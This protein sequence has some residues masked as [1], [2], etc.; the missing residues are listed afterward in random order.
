MLAPLRRAVRALAYTAAFTAICT[1]RA[2]AQSSPPSDF[3]TWEDSI[4]SSSWSARAFALFRLSQF[5]KSISATGR[6][7]LVQLLG[8]ELDGTIAPPAPNVDQGEEGYAEYIGTLTDLVSL[9]NDPRAIPYFA[10]LGVAHSNGARFQV[11][12]AGDAGIDDLVTTWNAAP[13]I[14]AGIATTLGLIIGYADSTGRPI[15]SSHRA[16]VRQ[17]LLLAATDSAPW[18]RAA[19]VDGAEASG[20]P[21]YLPVLQY[22]AAHDTAAIDGDRYVARE[23]STAATHL[24]VRL[25]SKTA[26]ALI[27][28]LSEQVMALCSAGWASPSGVCESF[29][30]KVRAAQAALG[31]S[32]PDVTIQALHAL[33]DEADAQRDKHLTE[34]GY[35]LVSGNITSLLGRL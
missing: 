33:Q 19:F 27:Q 30:A 28:A 18:V 9:F 6:D 25:S 8:R 15:T 2:A 11:A 31:R 7:R 24:T 21:S 4:L 34:T 10:R 13:S 17:Y 35:A 12:A 3:H 14:R 29:E 23:A 32:Q 16:T 26:A 22:L 20:D 1:I 5:P